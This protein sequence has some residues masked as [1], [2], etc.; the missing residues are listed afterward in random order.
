MK[1]KISV[2]FLAFILMLSMSMGVQANNGNSADIVDTAVASEDF[3]TLVAAV[4]AAGLVDALKGEGPFT[5]F[6]PTDEAFNQLLNELNLTAEQLLAS[7]ELSNILLYH[8]VSGKVMSSD[9]VDGMEV[10]TLNGEK[11]VISLDPV[12]VNNSTVVAADIETSNGV[13]HVIDT[14]LLPAGDQAV[15]EEATLTDIV[16]TA[17]AADNFQTLVAAVQAA[18]L[19]DALKGEGPFTVFAPTDEA[20]NQLLAELGVTAEQLL[21][22]ED[23]ADILLYH[24]VSGKV[25]STDLTD[26][27]EVE[28]LNGEK[29]IISLNPVKVNDS[30][31]VAADIEASNG[32]I[33]V[34]DAVLLP[35]GDEAVTEIPKTGNN[36][37]S[38]YVLLAILAGAVGLYVVRRT[39]TVR[40]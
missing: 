12:K 3:N 33:H 17:V 37:I 19:V 39:R 1:K 36:S 4:Q 13:I 30:N 8:V 31:V 40:A 16:D 15:E 22:R 28:T 20:F 18:G 6:A 7:D 11:I 26:G 25:L 32:V 23:L 35:I 2:L 27:M 5:V 38:M 10:E 34:I 14:V 9:L 29:I 21:A 24:V